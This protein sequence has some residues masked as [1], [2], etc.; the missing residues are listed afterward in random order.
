[1]DCPKRAN[2]FSGFS[3]LVVM[4]DM[5]EY[6]LL[7]Y[8]IAEP[9]IPRR[10]WLGAHEQSPTATLDR[11]RA[12]SALRRNSAYA[13]DPILQC[14]P[15]SRASECESWCVRRDPPSLR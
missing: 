3:R 8:E 12:S 11:C 5:F 13:A 10:S 14:P 6:P 9:V 15:G 1:M 4:V 2:C 7:V